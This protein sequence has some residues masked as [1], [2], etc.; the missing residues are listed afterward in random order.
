MDDSIGRMIA[1]ALT[2]LSA[3]QARMDATLT[4]ILKELEKLN[5]P[6]RRP[7]Q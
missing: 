5:S 3:T 4:A 7:K 1:G 6:F 2:Q